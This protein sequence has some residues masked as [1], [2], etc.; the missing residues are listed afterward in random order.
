[1]NITLNETKIIQDTRN[2]AFEKNNNVDEIVVTVDTDESW[3]YKLD[4]K[5]P[6]K[7]NI[8][9]DAL[10]NIIDLGRNG[11]ICSV[12]LTR[13][14]LPFNGKY[15]M[16]LRGVNGDKVYHS[17]TFEV[18][19]KYSIEPG[20]TYNPVPSEFY[21]VEA[22]LDDKVDE[23]KQYAENA[24]IAS[25]R[26]PKI[27]SD[28]TWLIW[29]A[30]TGDYV[31]T[32]IV[33]SGGTTDHSKLINRSAADQHPMSAITGLEK[34]LESKQPAGAYLT[35]KDLD[36]TLKE[37]GKAADAAE[38]GKRLSSLSE[39]IANLPQPDWNQND[40]TA[41]DYVKNRPFYTGDL[42]ETEI[43]D[44]VALMD[45]AGYRWL[46]NDGF[47][48]CGYVV[49]GD[50]L[51]F[52]TPLVAGDR[53]KIS[54]NGE[55][56][57]Y[58]AIDGANFDNPGL[59]YICDAHNLSEINPGDIHFI[60]ACAPYTR[61]DSSD[62]SGRW[63][64]YLAQDYTGTVPTE[65][66]VIKKKQEIKKID[67]IFLPDV[68]DGSITEEKLAQDVKAKLSKLSE[69]IADLSTL[70]LGVHT[71]G[72]VYIF[73]N[74]VPVG[75]GVKID[76]SI[77][78]DGDT[79]ELSDG[80]TLTTLMFSDDFDGGS[81]GGTWKPAYGHDNPALSNWWSA[82]EEN[83]GV[84][85]SCLRLTML[86]NNPNSSYEISG[87]KVETMQHETSD[88]YGFD[89]G[90]C[91]VK[92]KLDKV[93]SGIW[94]A[95]WCVGQTQTD[96]YS[97]ITADSVTRTVHGR[98]WPWAGEIDQLDGIGSAFTPGLIYQTDPYDSRLLTMKGSQNVS[99]EANTWYTIG[100]Y[101][102][103]D[104]IKVY[105]NRVLIDTFDISAINSFSGMGEKLI[106]NL[107]T[108]S[109][110]GTLPGDVNE[111]NMYVDYVKVY[112]LTD[113]YTTLAEQNV[114][115]LL[116]DYAEGF[117][118]V[119]G[120]SFLLYPQFAENTQNT[121]LYWASSNTA[122]AKVEN[123]YVTT[124]ANG[125]CTISATDADGNKVISFLMTV[126]ANAG[127][128]ATAIKITTNDTAIDMGKTLDIEAHI[129]PTNCDSLTPTLSV[130]S[131]SEYCTINGLTI[132]NTNT[133]GANQDVIVRVGTNNPN[134]Y[135]DVT[136][137]V[138]GRIVD[139]IDTNGI[140]AKYTR[141]G[142]SADAW[143]S[144]LETNPAV[145]ATNNDANGWTYTAGLG[146]KKAHDSGSV[147][148]IGTDLFNIDGPFT[149]VSRMHYEP[150]ANISSGGNAFEVINS[151]D[152]GAGN[153][154]PNVGHNRLYT[155]D[156]TATN[157][158]IGSFFG[159]TNR[160]TTDGATYNVVLVKDESR[161]LTVYINGVQTA[162]STYYSTV[163][164]MGLTGMVFRFPKGS[165]YTAY[166]QAM[167][168]Y[169]RAMTA[170]EIVALHEALEEM[171][172]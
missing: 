120:R 74:R 162:Q 80:I 136:L 160:D 12:T 91:E 103:K 111:V 73:L 106:I 105:W 29:D 44:L 157:R 22:R 134:V 39:E 138:V 42:V 110:A 33:A 127:I 143:T 119:A 43:F 60:V 34:A 47:K 2:L 154:E 14:M 56:G 64:I 155:K 141:K 25:T 158:Q 31:D 99:L 168:A 58:P 170:E 5:Y 13:E 130:V 123:G 21:Q 84:A 97:N 172:A 79:V 153:I 28:N 117:A 132:M 3:S 53:Y 90:Y 87:A 101:K 122:V 165:V 139:N 10:Y 76:G 89:T 148:T 128:L 108:G 93:G 109:L 92:F 88:N 69:E 147:A 52:D 104:V 159:D 151:D 129:Y 135:E 11:D 23:A 118:C 50:P 15:T 171:Y 94:P 95:I 126:K 125:E 18:W 1:M 142:W 124:V 71:D 161:N 65:L 82:G 41:A 100:L 32:G 49:Y 131:G 150:G 36:T 63:F 96:S 17:D 116:P 46:D 113:S 164:P 115:T 133:S 144:D 16:Q 85:D 27:S 6:D 8:G 169:N 4:V 146:Y 121:A 114:A 59:I 70:T 40:S 81:L 20:S 78:V 163:D 7:F 35:D 167:L 102:T 48:V 98:G 166:Y 37:T 86:R 57:E 66:K 77:V 38:V 149:L 107:S 68:P 140:V 83:L 67:K 26:M 61:I 30:E 72:L 24:E 112:S 62:T 51:C 156:A 75:T 9:K 54:Y 152:S 45:A 19:V 137:Q 145:A 55:T